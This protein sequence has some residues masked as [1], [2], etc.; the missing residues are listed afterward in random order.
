M[1]YHKNTDDSDLRFIIADFLLTLNTKPLQSL[2][3]G[4][5]MHA[6]CYMHL[7]KAS[8]FLKNLY[9]EKKSNWNTIFGLHVGSNN[10]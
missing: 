9:E 8:S 1:Q 7:L 4:L 6:L 5:L 10:V 3:T 2:M